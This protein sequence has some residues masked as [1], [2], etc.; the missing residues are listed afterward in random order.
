[1]R[2]RALTSAEFQVH[3]KLLDLLSEFAA[4]EDFVER[5]G[6][7]AML[8]EFAALARRQAFRP[9]SAG[10]PVQ[11]LG[12]LEASGECFDALWVCGMSDDAWPPHGAA[13]A[14]LPRALQAQAGA[15]H[16]PAARGVGF[17]RRVPARPP[18]RAAP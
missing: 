13:T 10:A 8:Q 11:V 14:Y 16:A 15:P 3:E 5:R 2:S 12:I 1:F 7:S 6:P 9:E 18:G 17:W 4:L